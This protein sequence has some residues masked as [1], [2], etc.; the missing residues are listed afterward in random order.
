MRAAGVRGQ[1]PEC[2]LSVSGRVTDITAPF[3]LKGTFQGGT[4]TLSFQPTHSDT[5]LAV[6]GRQTPFVVGAYT[7]AGGGSGVKVSGSGTFW[8]TGVIGQPLSLKYTGNGCANPGKCMKTDAEITLTP[9][10]Q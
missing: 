9:V 3:T 10:K 2:R 6:E 7:Y 5:S 1:H 4:A 8:I